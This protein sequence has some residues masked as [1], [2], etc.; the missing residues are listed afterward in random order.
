[1]FSHILIML[2]TVEPP[3]ILLASVADRH[4]ALEAAV[5][6]ESPGY[7]CRGDP[8]FV[9]HPLQKLSTKCL[10]A[11]TIY[12]SSFIEGNIVAPKRLRVLPPMSSPQPHSVEELRV[13][14]YAVRRDYA[15]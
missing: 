9:F 12:A 1:M 10:T 15:A 2:A 4:L 14:G 13:L 8:T 5:L 7:H 6:T 11:P 3:H